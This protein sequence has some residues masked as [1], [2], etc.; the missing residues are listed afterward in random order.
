[1]LPD[2]RADEHRKAVRELGKRT[3]QIS[4]VLFAALLV[5]WFSDLRPKVPDIR[6]A[7]AARK[8][9]AGLVESRAKQIQDTMEADDDDLREGASQSN[10][11]QISQLED[12][13]CAALVTPPEGQASTLS[14]VALPRSVANARARQALEEL[15]ALVGKLPGHSEGETRQLIMKICDERSKLEKAKKVQQRATGRFE[16]SRRLAEQVRFKFFGLEVGVKSYWAP[17]V[18][19]ALLWI[20]LLNLALAR[21]A[22]VRHAWLAL[23]LCLADEEAALPDLNKL[24]IVLRRGWRPC[25]EIAFQA[26]EKLGSGRCIG[27]ISISIGPHLLW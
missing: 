14:G 11:A 7:V 16:A 19:L 8:S 21:T 23:E 20:T 27:S 18:W 9:A 1:M 24:E 13:T 6:T 2:K 4:L 10:R 5:S 3:T 22:I 25:R 17:T 26:H 12:Q 15:S